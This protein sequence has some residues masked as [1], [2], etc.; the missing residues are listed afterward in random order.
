[1]RK[2][3]KPRQG[4]LANTRDAF[5]NE[6]PGFIDWVDLEE[7]NPAIRQGAERSQTALFAER[8]APPC[9]QISALP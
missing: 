1:M 2:R 6:A 4:V 5:R 9:C 8:F 7:G 3:D